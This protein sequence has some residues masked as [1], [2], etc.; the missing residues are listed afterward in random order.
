MPEAEGRNPSLGRGASE[1][2]SRS[3]VCG[4]EG[5]L[6]DSTDLST[7]GHIFPPREEGILNPEQTELHKEVMDE[8]VEAVPAPAGDWEE[9]NAF[10]NHGNSPTQNAVFPKDEPVHTEEKCPEDMSCICTSCGRCFAPNMIHVCDERMQLEE[11]RDGELL[12]KDV[13]LKFLP[14]SHEGVHTAEASFNYQEGGTF[15]I[16]DPN[17]LFHQRIDPE[18]IPYMC[19]VCGENCTC[20]SNFVIP[21]GIQTGEKPYKCQ[22]CGKYFARKADLVTHQRVHTGEKPYK[23]QECGKS[24]HQRQHLVSHQRTHTGEKPYKCPLCPYACGNLANLK[25]HGRIHSGDKPFRCRLCAYSCNQSMNLKRHM[26]RHTGEKPFQC[27]ICPYTTGHWDNY[28]RH[29]KV[30]GQGGPPEERPRADRSR[31]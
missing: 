3:F 31:P 2:V 11:N 14:N 13:D 21:Q 7:G 6:R 30:H 8:T 10:A 29:Q 9:N 15:S 22:D 25:R 17:F 28:K 24:F 12:V 4:G 20:G 16:A 26:L 19:P 1:A 23:C 27:R 5:G 18:G